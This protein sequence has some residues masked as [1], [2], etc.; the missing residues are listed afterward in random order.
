LNVVSP[1]VLENQAANE[2]STASIERRHS[3]IEVIGAF[4]SRRQSEITD[5]QGFS[6]DD[7]TQLAQFFIHG[8][9]QSYQKLPV[10]PPP[11]DRPPS[12]FG[13]GAAAGDDIA[14]CNAADAVLTIANA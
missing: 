6:A 12:K 3:A 13:L 9:S 14:G 11:P 5:P 2:K 10:A 8:V 4:L 1:D 7:V